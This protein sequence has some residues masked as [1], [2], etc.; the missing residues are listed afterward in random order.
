MKKQ[1]HTKLFN[2][3][4]RMTTKDILETIISLTGGI[5]VD[6]LVFKHFNVGHTFDLLNILLRPLVSLVTIVGIMIA[7][8]QLNITK[9]SY[10]D[11]LKISQLMLKDKENVY[12]LE[13]SKYYNQELRDSL[14]FT[15]SRYK[16]ILKE[17]QYDDARV[18]DSKQA[19][20]EFASINSNMNLT[21]LKMNHFAF[22]FK[23][24]MINKDYVR[25]ECN[26][27]L[28]TFYQLP[29]IEKVLIAYSEKTGLKEFRHILAD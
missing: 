10:Q 9:S 11:S 25:T 4:R 17:L 29:D 19:I 7:L 2:R 27:T 5:L 23:A 28:T 3:I 24:N 20:R 15:I 13:A 8:T 21:L 1:K 12:T 22:Y 18:S 16:R 14:L 26:V 6:E